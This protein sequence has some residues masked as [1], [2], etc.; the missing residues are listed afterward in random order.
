[1]QCESSY[2]GSGGAYPHIYIT[3]GYAIRMFSIGLTQT[4][5]ETNLIPINYKMLLEGCNKMFNTHFSVIEEETLPKLKLE[6]E[7]YWYESGVSIELDDI[8]EIVTRTSV[9]RLYNRVKLGSAETLN[10]PSLEFPETIRMV[11]FKQE[12]YYVIGKCNINSV[13]DLENPFVT[14]SNVIEYLIENPSDTSFD[15]KWFMIQCED[16]GGGSIQASS[17]QWIGA[18]TSCFY[19]EQL[20]N[21]NV[22]T[23]HNGAIP[24]SIALSLGVVDNRFKAISSTETS[25]NAINVVYDPTL[26]DIEINDVGSNYDAA[27]YKYTA[28][29]SG[30]YSF[31]VYIPVRFISTYPGQSQCS[32]DVEIN[33]DVYDAANALLYSLTQ[34]SGTINARSGAIHTL[35]FT[36]TINLNISEYVKVRIITEGYSNGSLRIDTYLRLEAGCVFECTSTSD[37]GGIYKSYDPEMYPVYV[38]EFKYPLINDS[39]KKIEQMPNGLI[40]FSVNGE[41][42]KS[43]WIDELKYN[44]KDQVASFKLISTKVINQ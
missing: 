17:G 3:C 4:D 13:K 24:N 25:Y 8:D 39:Y 33:F 14:S 11:G 20:T 30:A 42:Y 38:H 18:S 21:K 9:D 5:F 37:G 41:D 22:L 27:L 32:G 10:Y 35:D 36:D 29:Q 40:R 7:A 6:H 23:R 43:G 1:M 19:N 31:R 34:F 12:E 44:K 2:F 26:F 15:D 16:A 28:P